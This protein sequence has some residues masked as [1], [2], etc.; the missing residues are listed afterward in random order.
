MAHHFHLPLLLAVATS[1]IASGD[2]F[3]ASPRP[4]LKPR[5]AHALFAA[6]AK[7]DE[8]LAGNR[9][10]HAM[11]RSAN[12]TR[13]IAFWKGR[14]ARIL[15]GGGK[16]GSGATFM[17][18]G[19]YRDTE[20]FAL[21]L[22]PLPPPAKAKAASGGGGGGD[23]E[24]GST[25]AADAATASSLR[26]TALRFVGLSMLLPASPPDEDG[27]ASGS[28][29]ELDRGGAAVGLEDPL[30]RFLAQRA[31]KSYDMAGPGGLFRVRSVASAPGD[32]FARFVLRTASKERL[33]ETAAFYCDVLRMS[34]VGMPS[35]EEKCF[36]YK[37][38]PGGALVGVPTT[39]VFQVAD[40]AA[41]DGSSS[42]D[43]GDDEAKGDGMEEAAA[44]ECFDHLAICCSDIGAAFDHIREKDRAPVFLEPCEMFGTT[45]MGLEDPNGYKVYLVEEASFRAGAGV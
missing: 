31:T 33:V 15:S 45:I 5:H 18:Y 1:L 42:S 13:D 26:N 28:A 8:V 16:V 20:H 38:V 11:L 4:L 17:G 3:T 2:A 21:E 44:V 22:S 41:M 34:E 30:A 24:D 6:A 40:G 27:A 7:G 37:P 29:G 19:A 39:L 43:G 32:P 12:V 14:G 23:D 35:D 25:I 10:L 36:R 9:L